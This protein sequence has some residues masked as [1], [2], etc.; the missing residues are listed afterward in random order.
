MHEGTHLLSPVRD[1]AIDHGDV[2]A[3]ALALS[4]VHIRRQAR[5]AVAEHECDAVAVT[6]AEVSPGIARLPSVV[7]AEAGKGN[8]WVLLEKRHSAVP[9]PKADLANAHL[10]QS[11]VAACK[12]PRVVGVV[13]DLLWMRGDACLPGATILVNVVKVWLHKPGAPLIHRGA[14][15]VRGVRQE[16]LRGD[17]IFHTF[18]E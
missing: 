17:Y 13:V 14:V 5:R 9:T 18:D 15:G 7:Q 2:A 11:R 3:Q 8:A 12:L 1:S 16:P 10:A 6:A 4:R